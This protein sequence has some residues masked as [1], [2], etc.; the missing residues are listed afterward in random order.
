M[1]DAP[2]INT[3]LHTPESLNDAMLEEGQR[4]ARSVAVV[5]TPERRNDRDWPQ[6]AISRDRHA[7]GRRRHRC[8]RAGGRVGHLR[9]R[10]AVVPANGAAREHSVFGSAAKGGSRTDD[11][12]RHAG[13]L[14]EGAQAGRLGNG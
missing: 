9:V 1:A 10:R 3:P 4:L 14:P 13:T 8:R 7:A 11:M 5:V 6:L 2:T 12:R